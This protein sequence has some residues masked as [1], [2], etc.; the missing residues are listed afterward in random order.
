MK[1]NSLFQTTLTILICL[2][3]S[4]LTS[5]QTDSKVYKIMSANIRYAN[6]DDG[7]NIWENR[8][9]W[10]CDYVDFA[11]IDIFGGQEIRYSQ[12]S[13]ITNRLPE[14]TY[15]GIGREGDEK[16]E[17][18]PIFYKKDKFQILASNT[19]W[20]SAT[21]EKIASKGWDAALPRI[22]T[23]AKLKDKTNGSIF[24]FFNTHFDHRGEDARFESSKLIMGKM[25]NIAGD[26]PFF[27]SGDFNLPPTAKGYK[28]LTKK[29]DA[30]LVLK[31]AYLEAKKKYGPKYTTNGFALEP[32]EK[33]ERIDYIFYHGPI[34]IAKY[35]VLDG[36]RGRKHLSDHYL[37]VVDAVIN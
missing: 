36:Q 32:N 3:T 11:E 31:D 37:V 30:G 18:S 20:L 8:R 13:D 21:P 6:P 4:T 7:I 26:T 1:T 27:V 24:Y 2:L 14:Y 19:F 9:D 25:K 33:K 5:A 29:N 28:I 12:L 16:G 10:F 15:V 35:L 34:S 17:F 22:M 23:W